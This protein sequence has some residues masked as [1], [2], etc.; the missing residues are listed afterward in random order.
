M[1]YTTIYQSPLGK[2]LLACDDD[3]LLGLWFEGAKYYG[4]GLSEDSLVSHHHPILVK[5]LAWLEA[6]FSKQTLPE[7][8]PVKARG[9]SFRQMVWS[10]LLTIP[11]GQTMTY[12]ELGRRVAKRMGVKSMSAQAIGGA[13]GHNPLSLMI[14]CHRVLG[15]KGAL[16]GYA[17][18]LERKQQLLALEGV[19]ID[20]I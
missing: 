20:D 4:N 16:T 7:L 17:G 3:G 13:V 9:S 10:E 8:P 2:I 12:G 15:A 19:V 11:Y 14:P 6:Y 1:M 18:G 5:A